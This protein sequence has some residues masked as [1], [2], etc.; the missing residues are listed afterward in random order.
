[1]QLNQIVL[2]YNKKLNMN[3]DHQ[4]LAEAY[5][6]I[7][8]SENESES[9]LERMER[10]KYEKFPWIKDFEE[11]HSGWL[12]SVLYH[13]DE[14]ELNYS[15]AFISDNVERK[16]A[17]EF[18]SLVFPKL[19]KGMNFRRSDLDKKMGELVNLKTGE[20]TPFFNMPGIGEQMAS[21]EVAISN[22]DTGFWDLEMTIKKASTQSPNKIYKAF[23]YLFKGIRYLDAEKADFFN[24]LGI[25][26]E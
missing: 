4:L 13:E 3:K 9:I 8:L 22:V 19:K 20:K 16:D 6:K 12:S 24:K 2:N 11:K 14:D 17:M 25:D 23:E 10:I 18:A 21:Y 1:V 5:K 15:V 7:Y 26:V